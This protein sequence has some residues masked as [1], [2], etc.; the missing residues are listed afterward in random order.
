MWTKDTSQPP[1]IIYTPGAGDAWA[2]L[3]RVVYDPTAPE[4]KR[5]TGEYSF[6]IK[7]DETESDLDDG[8]GIS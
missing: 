8:Y 3:T 6:I 5:V 1:K 2:G 7:A 4:G